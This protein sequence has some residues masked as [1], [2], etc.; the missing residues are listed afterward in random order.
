M[1]VLEFTQKD[2]TPQSLN[3]GELRGLLSASMAQ[4]EA[5]AQRSVPVRIRKM[6][7][8]PM[9]RRAA[10]AAGGAL[11]AWVSWFLWTAGPK[12]PGEPF[13]SEPSG[14]WSDVTRPFELYRIASP[15][16]EEPTSYVAQRHRG[17]G[18]RDTMTFGD[19]AA[20]TPH[21]RMTFYRPAEE[22]A[23]VPS[24]WVEMARRAAD[25][26]LS[27]ERAA[28]P[29]HLKSRFGNFEAGDIILSGGAATRAC[30]GFR[31][32][33]PDPDLRISGFACGSRGQ[34]LDRRALGCLIDRIDLV[35][36]GDDKPLSLF[37]ARAEMERQTECFGGRGA[38]ASNWLSPQVSAPAL[39]ASAARAR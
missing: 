23:L 36:A 6:L 11:W 34:P 3:I 4:Q 16:L 21:V 10:L 26:A 28:T 30:V 24:F 12:P 31:I 25:G 9:A 33:V 29:D 8:G 1:N 32:A 18:R 19:P 17:G 38:K 5:R 39:R 37:F 27:V 22:K 14:M 35:A 2:R 7:A 20:D 13:P 15:D